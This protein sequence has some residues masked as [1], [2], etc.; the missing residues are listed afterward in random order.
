MSFF[1]KSP[2]ITEYEAQLLR[3]SLRRIEKRIG[4]VEKAAI[5]ERYSC[6][7]GAAA[8]RHEYTAIEMVKALADH[9]GVSLEKVDAVPATLVVKK[10][11][12]GRK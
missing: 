8:V 4:E 6:P 1:K 7:F 3:D 5:E 11:R 9:L 12:R 10:K 2:P